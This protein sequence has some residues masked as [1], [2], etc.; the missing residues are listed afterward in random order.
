M[1]EALS[2][3]EPCTIAAMPSSW[4]RSRSAAR[5]TSRST[6]IAA[7][8]DMLSTFAAALAQKRVAAPLSDRDRERCARWVEYQRAW[9]SGDVPDTKAGAARYARALADTVRVERELG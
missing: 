9:L 7:T 3:G 6:S 2:D 8:S 4:M 1:D 5:S